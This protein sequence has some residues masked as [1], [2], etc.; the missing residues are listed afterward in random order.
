MNYLKALP[1]GL[2]IILMGCQQIPIKTKPTKPTLQINAQSD[3]GICLDRYN[4]IKLGE[5]ILELE[6]E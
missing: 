5:Y 2:L 3:G 4:A 1:I 6:R